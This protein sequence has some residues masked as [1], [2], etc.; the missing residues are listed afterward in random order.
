[1]AREV[2]ALQIAIQIIISKAK[3]KMIKYTL[4]LLALVGALAVSAKAD[5]MFLGAIPF[6]PPN[7]PANNQLVLENFLGHPIG[8]IIDNFEHLGTNHHGPFDVTPGEFFIVHYGKGKGG[9]AKGGSYEFFQVINNETSVTFPAFGNGSTNPDAY[10]HGGISSARGFP[11][12]SAPD[13]GATVMLLGGALAV[14]GL[15][16]HYLK[17]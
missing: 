6:G 11:G 14:L 12:P 4:T 9:T 2:L 17:R 13:N 5:L 15:V 16:R 10:G 1:M 3:M 7:S 8:D